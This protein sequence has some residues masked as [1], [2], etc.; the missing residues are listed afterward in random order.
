MRYSMSSQA[1]P[2]ASIFSKY[3]IQIS[4]DIPLV[5]PKSTVQC[6]NLN[7]G[8]EACV[9]IAYGDKIYKLSA[10]FKVGQF[11]DSFEWAKLLAQ[12]YQVILTTGRF[13]HCVWMEA[14]DLTQQGSAN[15]HATFSL[16]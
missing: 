2:A 10:A 3:P 1:Q 11:H 16:A 12:D 7:K 13:H 9:G 15:I 14:L 4:P 8:S 5:M 6:F